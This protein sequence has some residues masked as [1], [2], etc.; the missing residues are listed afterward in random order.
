[1][2]GRRKE[3]FQ[4]MLAKRKARTTPAQ[5]FERIIEQALEKADKVDCSLSEYIEGLRDWIS[6]LGP[7]QTN[8]GA[9]EADEER[10]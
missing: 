10:L 2:S 5:H 9:A 6:P 3:D 8:I 7:I 4:A 1:M